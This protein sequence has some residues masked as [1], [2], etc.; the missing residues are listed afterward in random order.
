[1]KKLLDYIKI[2]MK[3]YT[4]VYECTLN[5]GVVVPVE[6]KKKI[7]TKSDYDDVTDMVRTAIKQQNKDTEIDTSRFYIIYMIELKNR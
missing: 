6:R 7:K 5:T 1:M 2:K 3:N 4:Y